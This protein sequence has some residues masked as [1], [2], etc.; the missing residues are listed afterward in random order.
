MLYFAPPFICV[1]YNIKCQLAC[2]TWKWVTGKCGTVISFHKT[3]KWTIYTLFF[4]IKCIP[5]THTF[6]FMVTKVN[7]L[8]Q[9]FC[10]K[11]H[12]T[13]SSK[14]DSEAWTG[15]FASSFSPANAGWESTASGLQ[16]GGLRKTLLSPKSRNMVPISQA[17]KSSNCT[18]QTSFVKTDPNGPISKK[19]LPL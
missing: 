16:E 9:N 3:E 17:P 13:R 11:F 18:A 10:V 2:P 14:S 4:S 19:V 5:P 7:D 1:M 12:T 6:S 8:H 15:D